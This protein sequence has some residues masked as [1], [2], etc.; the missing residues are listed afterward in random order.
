MADKNYTK[1]SFRIAQLCYIIIV[2]I[3]LWMLPG[4]EVWSTCGAMIAVWL[5]VSVIYRYTPWYSNKGR[6]I[7]LVASTLLSVGVIANVH[8]FTV[9]LG[10]TT[11]LPVLNNPDAHR[12]YYDALA[13]VGHPVGVFSPLKQHGYGLLISWL[14]RITGIT[15]VSPLVVNMMAILLCIIVS[16]G[17]TW[18]VLRN[19]GNR[20]SQSTIAMSL[21]AVVCYYLNSGTLLLKEAGVCFAMVL[22]ALSFTG[23]YA[24]P[25][26]LRNKV[27][28]WIGFGVGCI[29]LAFMRH[30]YLLMI[31]IGALVMLR[32]N[33]QS[34]ATGV[35]MAISGV[36]IMVVCAKLTE[37]PSVVGLPQGAIQGITVKTSF[38]YDH[39]QHRAYNDI[40]AGYFDI[41]IWKRLL[42]LPM[43]AVVQ[44]LVPFPWN[45]ARDMG[46]GYTLAYAHVAY[47][48]YAVGG[49]VLYYLFVG[50]H[51]SPRILIRMSLC[52]V[53]LWLIPAY[54]FAGT[55]SR[56]GLPMLPMLVPS[57]VYVVACCRHSRMFRWWCVGYIVLLVLTLVVAYNLQQSAM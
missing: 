24:T 45:F 48:W 28:L 50:W 47:P 25:K 40:V 35:I 5:C 2:L 12:Y 11:E 15:I 19:C 21:T 22:V 49:L 39:A 46:F 53:V 31:P 10:G 41:P 56:Y 44:Y 23:I 1:H 3:A 13:S 52:G 36:A 17:I 33:R 42:Y 30:T 43:S 20:T 14:W 27:L 8:Y 34:V 57:A 54:L 32:W 29:L 7:L 51:K 4:A 55:V 38:F 16:G 9:A 37:E 6:W 18:Q 26:M